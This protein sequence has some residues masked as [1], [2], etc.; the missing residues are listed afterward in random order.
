MSGSRRSTTQQSNGRSPA[1]SQRLGAGAD[2]RDLDVV[3]QQQLDDAL[4]LDVVVLDHQ[5]PLLVR[6]DVGLDAI[7]GVL[8]VLGRGRLDQVRERAVRQAV[9]P[10]LLDRQHLHRDVARRR[11]ELQV[12]EHGPAQ[13]VGQEHVERDRGRQVLLAPA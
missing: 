6:R 5:Q 8:E 9:L 13:H 11:I 7:E 1:A 2:R 3:V 4:P 12:V 10:L